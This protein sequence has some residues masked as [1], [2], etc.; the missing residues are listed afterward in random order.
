MNSPHEKAVQ[1][2]IYGHSCAMR[3]KVQLGDPM[4]ENGSVSSYDLA[5]SI[6][7][8]FSNAIAI[9]SDKPNTEDDQFS[10]L[11]SRDSSPP[12]PPP[13]P[14]PPASQRS[15][16]KKRKISSTNS[17]EKWKN[18]SPDPMYHDGFLWRKYGQKSIKKS[19][20]QRS[21]YRCSYNIDHACGARKHEQKIKDNPPV[22]RTTYFGHHTCKVNQ[23]QD[24]IFTAVRDPV[25]DLESARMIRFGEDIDQEKESHS[26]GFSLS[27][28]HEEDIINKETVD[29]CR[30]ITGDD[31]DCQHVIEE[32]NQSPPSGSSYAP[33]SSSGS[34][35]DMFDSDLLVEN[36]NLWDFYD[37]FDFGWR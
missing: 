31:Q 20:H 27:V 33:P 37:Q 5:K 3:L 14:P 28:K 36:L 26:S 18:D 2:I 15:H 29:Q 22:Y 13:P 32:I 23:N 9:L 4:A 30:E 8:C 7:N 35:S 12:P 11:S 25:N 1:A 24:A 16:S 17:S 34:E 6:V 21:Y 10:D 19:D